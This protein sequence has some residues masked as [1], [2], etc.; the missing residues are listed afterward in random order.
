M[1]PRARA[2]QTY[3]LA[4][5]YDSLPPYEYRAV[6]ARK[7]QKRDGHRPYGLHAKQVSRDQNERYL[8]HESVGGGGVEQQHEN[9]RFPR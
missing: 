2:V 1:G 6:A 8:R 4:G 7:H 9:Q 5:V 3:S